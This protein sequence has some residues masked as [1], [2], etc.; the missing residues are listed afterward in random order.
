MFHS[1][2]SAPPRD[3]S[4]MNSQDRADHLDGVLS[5]TQYQNNHYEANPTTMKR[6]GRIKR[7]ENATTLNTS[8]SCIR[9]ACIFKKIPRTTCTQ[10]NDMSRDAKKIK[11]K[12]K[13]ARRYAKPIARLNHHD[14][15]SKGN[16]EANHAGLIDAP[17]A[18]RIRLHRRTGDS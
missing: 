15:G 14:N 12:K 17:G 4:P 3:I 13:S 16:G 7:E 2:C 11:E 8:L 1:L 9:T 10:R 5:T 18:S 6:K